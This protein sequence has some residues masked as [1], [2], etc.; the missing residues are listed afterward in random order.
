MYKQLLRP[1]FFRF[2]PEKVHHWSFTAIRVV[3]RLGFG[4]LVRRLFTVRD[5]RLE[6]EVFGLKFP[7]PVGLGAG[8]DKDA[9]LFRELSDFG[10]G[11]IEIGTLTP[12]PQPGNPKKRLFRLKA[13]QAIINR[14]GFNN[15]GVRAAAERLK[16]PHRVLIGG[17]IGK[18]KVTPNEEAEADYLFCLRELYPFVDYFVVNVSSPNTPGLRELQ[19]KEPLTRLLQTLKDEGRQL[20]VASGRR[21]KPLLLKIAPDLN[22]AQLRD[23]IEIMAETRIDGVIATNTTVDRTGLKSDPGLVNQAGGLSGKPLRERSTEV[24]R[25][26]VEESGAAFPV[27]GVGGIHSPEDALE[28][29]EAGASLVQLWTGFIYEG[30]GLVRKINEALL[31]RDSGAQ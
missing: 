18:N 2:D 27:I 29:L 1:V 14:M 26:L 19:E 12:K 16:I 11:F 4:P 9:R 17:N 31:G 24:I 6:R 21:E 28:K 23:I 15:G 8:F 22:E 30:P 20:A 7:N 5:P 25:F 3:H 10:F 13:D